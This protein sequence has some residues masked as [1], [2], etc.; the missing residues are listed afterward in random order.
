VGKRA[1]TLREAAENYSVSVDTLR[2]AIKATDP[3]A[4]PPPLTARRHGTA[5]NSKTT[6]LVSEM[7]RWHESIT[8]A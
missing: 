1:L 5:S 8:Q 2:K 3:N 6:V 4:Y 7:D